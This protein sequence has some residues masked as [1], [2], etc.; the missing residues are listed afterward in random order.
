MSWSIKSEAA[1]YGKSYFS[2][3]Y[4]NQYGKTYLEDF[5]FIKKSCGRRVMELN[6][7]LRIAHYA[8][9]TVLDIGCA[10]GPFLSA[11]NDK[12]W[13]VFGT[14]IAEENEINE[15]KITLKDMTTGE[16]SLVTTDELIEKVK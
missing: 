3:Q 16:Q 7:T 12:G 9:P 15:Q 4:K 14:D 11:A 5:E 2:E 8:K 1:D 6:S 10:Y 13:Q